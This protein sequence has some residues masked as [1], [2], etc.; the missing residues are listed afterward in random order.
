V[1]LS[2]VSHDFLSGTNFYLQEGGHLF[3]LKWRLFLINLAFVLTTNKSQDQSLDIISIYSKWQVFMHGQ[4]FVALWSATRVQVVK[5]LIEVDIRGKAVNIN[6][7][8][9][10]LKLDT[11]WYFI[12][13]VFGF[14]F[15]R[16]DFLL[17]LLI[18][19]YRV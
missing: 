14:H 13:F 1:L 7:P 5:I 4:F 19:Y 17:Y 2:D 8:E 10:W 18:L 12:S 15:A 6:F 9:V 11:V 16:N 3:V